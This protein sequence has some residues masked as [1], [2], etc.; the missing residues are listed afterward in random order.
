MYI[1]GHGVE[2]DI[3]RALLLF[4][5]AQQLDPTLT[6]PEEIQKLIDQVKALQNQFPSPSTSTSAPAPDASQASSSSKP[7]T[8]SPSSPKTTT[9][10]ASGQDKSTKNQKKPSNSTK[11][12]KVIIEEMPE[13][14]QPATPQQSVPYVSTLEI[15]GF[16]LL[17]TAVVATFIFKK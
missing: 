1:G 4:Q 7:S 13:N 16:V 9:K 8:S 3:R 12:S 5:V 11:P 14:A 2:K 6:L 10:P 17:A 15:I